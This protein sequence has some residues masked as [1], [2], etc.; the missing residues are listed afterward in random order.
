MLSPKSISSSVE[1]IGGA[2]RMVPD[3]YAPV[4]LAERPRSSA[5]S[6]TCREISVELCPSNGTNSI[7]S[8][9]PRPRTSPMH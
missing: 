2:K 8:K 4:M 3:V 5:I 1:L 6:V 7:P 9:S